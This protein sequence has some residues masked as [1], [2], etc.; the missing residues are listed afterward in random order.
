MKTNYDH[1][2]VFKVTGSNGSIDIYAWFIDV[3]VA[4][5]TTHFDIGVKNGVTAR[6]IKG[7]EPLTAEYAEY[8]SN[9]IRIRKGN[10]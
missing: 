2:P 1:F 4:E 5:A 3:A 10:K 9:L 8:D 6:W 7:N